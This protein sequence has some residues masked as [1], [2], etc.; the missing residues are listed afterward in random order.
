MNGLAAVG[1][2]SDIGRGNIDS[3]RFE[4]IHIGVLKLRD[5]LRWRCFSIF[6]EVAAAH[7]M[8]RDDQPQ[9]FRANSRAVRNDKIAETKKRLVFLPDR[10]VEKRV[11]ADDEEDAIA[12]AVIGVA[13]VAYRIDGIV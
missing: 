5:H 13:E 11:G 2:P 12:V 9:G 10:N 3:N 6:L 1:A 4:Q 7:Q 8:R